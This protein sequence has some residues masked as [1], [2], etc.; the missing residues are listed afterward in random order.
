MKKK[1]REIKKETCCRKFNIVFTGILVS[2]I[3]VALA[4]YLY[5]AWVK[6]EILIPGLPDYDPIQPNVPPEDIPIIPPPDPCLDEEG[7]D[8]NKTKPC[9]EGINCNNTLPNCTE[10]GNCLIC[11][12]TTGKCDDIPL[13]IP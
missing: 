1:Y 13:P 12:E 6:I 4:Y 8:C 9:P 10:T 11:N 7:I 5:K 2:I 3:S